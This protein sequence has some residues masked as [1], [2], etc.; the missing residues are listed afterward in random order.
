VSPGLHIRR[1]VTPCPSDPQPAVALALQ[2]RLKAVFNLKKI[3]L[4]SRG[5]DFYGIGPST[6]LVLKATPRAWP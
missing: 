4:V 3:E 6:I 2:F 1:H 5:R